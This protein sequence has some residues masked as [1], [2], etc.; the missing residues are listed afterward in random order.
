LQRLLPRLAALLILLAQGAPPAWSQAKAPAKPKE[1]T[2]IEAE[3]IEGVS[4]L[5]VTARG[6]VEFK[7]EDLTLYS[8]FLRYNQEFG[9]VEA[10]GGVRLKR[11]DDRFFG[12]RL[13]YN[14][15]DDT[16]VFEQSHFILPG[17]TT[18][19]RGKAERMEFLGKSRTRLVQGTFSTCEPNK[20]DWRVEAGELVIDHDAQR[21]TVRDGRLKFY[22]VTVLPL[23]YGSFSLDNQRKSGFL[24]P[25]YENNTRRGITGALPYY[26]NIA[27]EQ[28]VT[29]IPLVMSK[30]GAQL[31]SE[32]RYINRAYTGE[33]HYDY[34]P[35]DSQLNRSR[36]ALS[37]QHQQNLILP[38]LSGRIDY[39]RVSDSRYFVD[40]TSQVRQVSQGIL[41]QTGS[42]YYGN[43]FAGVPYGASL[44]LQRWQTLQDP[45]A[46]ITPPY[47]RMPQLNFNASKADLAGRFDLTLPAEYVRFD[48]PTFVRGTRVQ[49]NPTVSA[50]VLAPGY[51]ITP[52]LG[53]HFANY[54]LTNLTPGTPE[55]QSVT[56]PWASLDA[57]LIYDRKTSWFGQALTQTLEP[58]AF[59]VYAPNRN[60]NLVP[61]FDT[62]LSDFNYAQ[63]FTEN[64]FAGG[65]RFGDANQ[66][67][68]AA[69]SRLI[70]P[71]GRELLRATI[72]QRYYFTDEHVG[73]TPTST[74]RTRG[75]SDL[76]ASIGGRPARELA[77]DAAVQY[78]F[79]DAQFERY[80]LTARYAP[81]IA[82]VISAGYR[83]NR[84]TNIHQVD[85]AGQWPIATGWY[86]VGR[87]TYSIV[88]SRVLE[89]I[90]GIE[91]NA[92][93][94]VLRGAYQRIQAATNTTSSGIF[95]QL[96]LNGFGSLGSDDIVELLKRN[97]PG[98]AVTNP[99]E[100]R[101]IPPSLRPALP[102]QQTY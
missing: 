73:L 22:D 35:N 75:Q 25:Y 95:L 88:D 84:A 69:T 85:A 5:E 99:T 76:L 47:A 29:L 2:T 1:P 80:N 8:E 77:F 63:I 86:A 43:A 65:D 83:Y 24:T 54:S 11:G 49:L 96:E 74:L 57:G 87:A 38:G 20:E 78:N 61:I 92:G 12:L 82:K 67:T 44:M 21:G 59:Y 51:F 13:R 89:S 52:K 19:M 72:G 6:R 39:N 50:P 81:E 60:Q 7:R 40:L 9:R 17:E 97:I 64:R 23:P 30:R 94:W 41:Q 53:A 18:T 28:D 66:L 90:A 101:L 62:G 70:T 91:Y 16:G 37:I 15:R 42:L 58:R 34:M 33:A 68:L 3:K 10:D 93:C 79:Q 48:H 36:Y 56:V 32:Y 31:K 100:S 45:L 71:E 98:Y 46:P 4:E 102:F 26:W 14:T 27:P 55:S